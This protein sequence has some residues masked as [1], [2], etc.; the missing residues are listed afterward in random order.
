[1]AGAAVPAFI[2]PN[3]LEDFEGFREMALAAVKD[4]LVTTPSR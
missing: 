4:K 1:M 3:R 2:V